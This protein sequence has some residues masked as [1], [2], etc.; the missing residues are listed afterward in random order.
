MSATIVDNTAIAGHIKVVPILRSLG[1]KKAHKNYLKA[2]ELSDQRGTLHKE[3]IDTAMRLAH[4]LAQILHE[5]QGLS[6]LRE[7]MSYRASRIIEVF[8]VNRHSAAVTAAE[9]QVFAKNPEA[10]ANR[11]YGFGNPKKAQELGNTGQNDGWLFRGGG[12]MMNTGK[13]AY[14]RLSDY[15]KV[16]LLANPDL[17]TEPEYA[18]FPAIYA[19]NQISANKFADANNIRAITKGINGGYNGFEDRVAWFNKVW[20]LLMAVDETVFEK[21]WQ[22]VTADPKIRQLQRNLNDLGATPRLSVDGLFGPATESAVRAFQS[23]NGIAVDGIAGDATIAALKLRTGNLRDTPNS[24]TS[25]K[26]TTLPET[27]G[28]TAVAA[29]ILG[30][31]LVTKVN[32]VKDVVGDSAY[33]QL[34]LTA[35]LGLGL[36]LI[37]YGIITKKIYARTPITE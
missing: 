37:F 20:K 14:R 5:S 3:G 7:N 18:L 10:L 11:V 12:L 24:L 1:L 13:G 25:K 23:A 28:Y 2:F 19:W 21:P 6:V 36:C 9:A 22:N 33:I 31:Q 17:I 35:A 30:D 26:P 16:D 27:S 34:I 29:S 8:G 32:E 15:I 4:F